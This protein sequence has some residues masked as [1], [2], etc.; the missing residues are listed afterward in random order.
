M[1]DPDEFFIVENEEML[2]GI[3]FHQLAR[4]HGKRARRNS[5]WIFRHHLIGGDCFFESRALKT[6]PES[7]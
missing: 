5:F 2:N 4:F 3:G 6:P 1:N 7:S